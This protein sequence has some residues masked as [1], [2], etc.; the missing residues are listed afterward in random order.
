MTNPS[1]FKVD[2]SPE[3]QLYKILQRQSYGIDSALSEF[4]DNSIQSF[5]D[6]EKALRSVDGT[7][8]QLKVVITVDT[9]TN[10]IIIEDNAAGINRQNFQRAIRMGHDANT[11]HATSS[12]SVYGIGMKS[13]S[14]WFSNTWEIETSALGSQEKLIT[15]FD[16]D[17][18]LAENEN[19]IIVNT[20]PEEP[21]KHY[22]K[23]I[24]TN[25]LREEPE[26]HYHDRVLP[27][28]E[29]IFF[30]FKKFL[31]IEI[32]YDGLV[33]QTKGAFLNTPEPLHYP[34]VDTNG[35]PINGKYITWKR[36]I[37]FDYADK[38]VKGYI[39]IMKTGSY[40][41]PGIR[42]MRNQR[43]IVGTRISPNKP[44]L[45][46]GTVNKYASQRIYG[47]LHLN[48]S[49]INFMK[50]GFDYNLDGLYRILQS[51]LRGDKDKNEPNF[52]NQA[53]YYRARQK[54]GN[55]KSSTPQ[56]STPQKSTPQKSTPK[57][58]I[59]KPN[60]IENSE[61]I[62]SRLNQLDQKKLARLYWSICKISLTEHP[63]LVYVGSWT[64]LESLATYLDK[65]STTS[66][67]SFYSGKMNSMGLDKTKKADLRAS[68]KDI[69][70]KGNCNKHSGTYEA[71]D[72]I[73]L[74]ND[75]KVIED[76]IV[77]CIEEI[78]T[79]EN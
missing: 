62:Y 26:N 73:Q 65:D 49:P 29:E 56:K 25:S 52:I 61:E 35:T 43:V 18:L 32:I 42:L 78:L 33:L 27:Y 16:L 36:K 64:L 77:N 30:K 6:R 22:T 28:L 37:E 4:I 66:F 75:F 71:M 39:M 79:K 24:I 38:K 59:S 11:T 1:S 5:R 51:K 7:E 74:H 19:H 46:L 67:D 50:T 2:V 17:A 15:R 54:Q 48:D 44:L 53:N 58:T 63:I 34:E 41:Q 40:H 20:E 31:K 72:A 3:M 21:K 70:T 69:H 57:Q 9:K 14:I 12:L 8:V 23:I 10:Q 76:F 13:A 68:I 55:P 47:E 45:I 60:N